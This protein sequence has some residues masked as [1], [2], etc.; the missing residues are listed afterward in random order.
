M[1]NQSIDDAL[2][3]FEMKESPSY[4]KVL[5]KNQIK[6][7]LS[8]WIVHVDTYINLVAESYGGL[9]RHTI[10]EYQENQDE[11]FN[12]LGAKEKLVMHK[13]LLLLVFKSMQLKSEKARMFEILTNTV[14]E[15]TKINCTTI[16]DEHELDYLLNRIEPLEK[17]VNGNSFEDMTSF[18]EMFANSKSLDDLSVGQ[19]TQVSI[20]LDFIRTF[21]PR[22]RMD[23]GYFIDYFC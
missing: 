19:H 22:K 15:N 4:M 1:F 13:Y 5:C 8:G 2:F 23:S 20:F 21:S 12:G 18:T 7:I 14:F 16:L 9:L 10:Y 11:L 6:K 3:L 17:P